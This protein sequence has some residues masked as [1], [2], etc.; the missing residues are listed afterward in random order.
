MEHLHN[1][2]FVTHELANKIY[3]YD[4]LVSEFKRCSLFG[5][6]L[7][8]DM[9]PISTCDSNE[10]P[11]MYEEETEASAHIP[12]SYNEACKTKMTNLV[13]ELVDNGIL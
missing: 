7:A 10:A 6:G 2:K 13:C 12:Y 4:L 11:D 3:L 1:T 5:L 8:V 9:I